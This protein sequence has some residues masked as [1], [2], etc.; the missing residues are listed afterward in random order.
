MK[1][2]LRLYD[3]LMIPSYKVRGVRNGQN[4]GVGA[5]NHSL[6]LGRHLEILV[7]K[8]ESFHQL[9]GFFFVV[10]G[11]SMFL[12]LVCTILFNRALVSTEVALTCRLTLGCACLFLHP[13]I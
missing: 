2:T 6:P 5:V 10:E 8:S 1:E 11:K 13:L 12:K 7:G 9:E 4:D 3:P